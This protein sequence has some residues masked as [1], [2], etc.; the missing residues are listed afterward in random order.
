MDR[1]LSRSGLGA[2]RHADTDGD[3]IRVYVARPRKFLR[4]STFVGLCILLTLLWRCALHGSCAKLL[5]VGC[6]SRLIVRLGEVPFKLLHGCSA[7]VACAVRRD[8]GLC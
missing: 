4:A 1:L 7:N 5:T 2:E 6:P 8:A 3:I